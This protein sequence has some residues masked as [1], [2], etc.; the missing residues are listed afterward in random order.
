M[1]PGT[2]AFRRETEGRKDTGE[3]TGDKTGIRRKKGEKS[4]G[5]QASG[6]CFVYAKNRDHRVIFRLAHAISICYYY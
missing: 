3:G 1:A 5:G 4:T 6:C 2:L